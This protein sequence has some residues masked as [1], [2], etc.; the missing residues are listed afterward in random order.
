[1]G[2]DVRILTY[3]SLFPNK[4]KPVLGIFIFQRVFHFARRPGNLVQVIAPVP[5]FPR[6]IRWSRWKKEGQVPDRESIGTL[7]VRHPRFFLIPKISMPFHGLLLFLGSWRL[8]SR[9]H[10]EMQ[11]DCIDAHFVY[12]DGFAAVLLGKL[13]RIPVVVSARGTDINQYPGFRLIRPMI[14]WTLRNASGNIAVSA[15]LKEVMIGLGTAESSMRVIGNGI[16]PERFHP[17]D[18]SVARERL[19]LPQGV[20]ILVSVGGLIPRKGFHFL[21][22]AF[23]QVASRFPGSRLY[24]L[25][26][27]EFRSRLEALVRESKL[28]DRIF[29]PGSSPNE[30]LH[31]W[32]SAANLSCLVSSREGWP[33]VLQESLACGTPVLATKVWGAPEVVVSSELGFLV[34]QDVSAIAESLAQ[35]LEKDWNRGAIAR[36]AATRTWAV[37][38]G[39]MEDYLKECVSRKG[40]L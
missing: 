4:V 31:F 8:A 33:N 17:V 13:L 39:E 32:F 15:S 30:E 35:A 36:H 27:G 29:L 3:T 16:D 24:I 38:A 11:F 19:G 21:I 14:R 5:F 7:D 20:P 37:V 9:L 18:P 28:E 26:E 22:P 25:G 10:R 23:A 2:D 12:P 1:V 34:K 6:W 40:S